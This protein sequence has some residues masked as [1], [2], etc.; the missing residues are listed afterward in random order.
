MVDF[1]GKNDLFLVKIQGKI[2]FQLIFSQFYGFPGCEEVK[3]AL[4]KHKFIVITRKDQYSKIQSWLN[5]DLKSI[6]LFTGYKLENTDKVGAN[7]ANDQL[8]AKA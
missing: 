7:S 2:F 3:K 1:Q 8:L 6:P 4:H 5:S